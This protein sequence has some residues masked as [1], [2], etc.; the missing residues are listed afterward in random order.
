MHKLIVVGFASHSFQWESYFLQGFC[1]M[2]PALRAQHGTGTHHN[3]KQ[4]LVYR[5]TQLFGL[6]GG[7]LGGVFRLQSSPDRQVL[8]IGL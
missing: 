1:H 6:Q 7:V 5:K 8:V 2:V 4:E 3:R